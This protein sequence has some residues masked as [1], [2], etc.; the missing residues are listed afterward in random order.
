VRIFSEEGEI[1]YDF[2][3]EGQQPGQFDAPQDL[4]VNSLGHI[5]VADTENHRVQV[6][7]H[8]GIYLSSLGK[9]KKDKS[10]LEAALLAPTAVAIDSRDRVFVLDASS[11]VIKI[12]DDQGQYLRSMGSPGEE[13]GQFRDVAD[14]TFDENDRLYVAEKGNHRIQVFDRSGEWL[15]SFGSEGKGG[16][17]FQDISAVCA[18]EGKVYVADKALEY[19]QVFRYAPDGAKKGGRIYAT[20]TAQP[21]EDEDLNTVMRYGQA[22]QQALNETVKELSVNTG[23]DPS[24]IE[25][26][27]RIESVNSLINGQVKVTVSIPK[28]M[29]SRP[30]LEKEKGEE[31]LGEP[32]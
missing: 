2:G 29:M 9:Q 10:S 31:G 17:Y 1:E 32:K 16:G 21:Y 24:A 14:I 5:Y 6:F 3:Q 22:R 25:D 26:N 28:T 11:Q 8:D 23:L 7:N 12:Y 18:T 27:L 15:M 13:Y 20:Q 4:A 19:L 30:V